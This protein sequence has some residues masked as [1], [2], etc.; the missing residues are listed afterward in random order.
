MRNWSKLL[1]SPGSAMRL[2]PVGTLAHP[3]SVASARIEIMLILN[4]IMFLLLSF[5]RDRSRNNLHPAFRTL[6]HIR[7]ITLRIGAVIPV[8]VL[9]LRVRLLYICR[10]LLLD[11]S[12]RCIVRI[13]VWIIRIVGSTAP[14]WPPPT[15]SRANPDPR[16][17]IMTAT[18][19]VTAATIIVTATAIIVTATATRIVTATA[20]IVTATATM[21]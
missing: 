6:V 18:I 15:P 4:F 10:R 19:I 20:I 21:R 13:I 8:K 1:P 11:D 2:G 7:I 9:W 3:L 16:A 17:I 14:P 12:R 5:L